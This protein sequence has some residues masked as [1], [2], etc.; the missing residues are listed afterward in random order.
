MYITC[1]STTNY[2]TTLQH[3]HHHHDTLSTRRT[4]ASRIHINLMHHAFSV[5]SY[6]PLYRVGSDYAHGHTLKVTNQ[7]PAHKKICQ[8]ERKNVPTS[9]MNSRTSAKT[10]N[11]P[12]WAGHLH[13]QNSNPHTSAPHI[14][15]YQSKPPAMETHQHAEAHTI[16]EQLDL[17]AA[18]ARPQPGS[19]STQ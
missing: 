17:H 14:P 16:T 13:S 9:L 10:Q 18:T 11:H 6:L 8:N 1:I 2:N 4:N 19:R 15:G 3:H 12:R 5:P 7:Q